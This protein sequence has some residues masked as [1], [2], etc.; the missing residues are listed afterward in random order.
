MEDELKKELEDRV[1]ELRSRHSSEYFSQHPNY[2]NEQK[3]LDEAEIGELAKSFEEALPAIQELLREVKK[4][5]PFIGDR[6][7]TAA[8]YLLLG[9]ALSNLKSIITVAKKGFNLEVM[10]LTRSG[11]ESLDLALLFL[12]DGSEHLLEQW[13]N[14]DIV[15]NKEA[16]EV[17]HQIMNREL[18]KILPDGEELPVNKMKA[19]MYKLFSMYT[20]SAYGA[21]FDSI[22]VFREDIDFSGSAGFHYARRNFGVIH[23]FTVSLILQLKNIFGKHEDKEGFLRADTL[24]KSLGYGDAKFEDFVGLFEKDNADP[25]ASAASRKTR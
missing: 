7:K 21:L 14:G 4:F 25:S 18:P 22:D 16:R 6:T 10:D 17:M 2:P 11:Q 5:V 20:H 19:H 13:F 24:Y 9:K 12:E 1:K 3:D 23:D 8:A 15:K